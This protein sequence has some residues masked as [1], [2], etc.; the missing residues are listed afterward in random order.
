MKKTVVKGNKELKMK[1]EVEK[2]TGHENNP[3][4]VENKL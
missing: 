4:V 1:V 3:E 2:R